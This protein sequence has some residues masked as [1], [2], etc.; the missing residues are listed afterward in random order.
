MS[1]SN[2]RYSFYFTREEYPGIFEMLEGKTV[3]LSEREVDFLQNH[4]YGTAIITE[5]GLPCVLDDAPI[6]AYMEMVFEQ[7]MEIEESWYE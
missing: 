3:F 5:G 7:E 4:F 6:R 2:D 1:Y